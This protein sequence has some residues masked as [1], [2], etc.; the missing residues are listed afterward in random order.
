MANG[1]PERIRF[2]EFELDVRAG[3]LRKGKF[4]VRLQEQ[5]LQLLLVLLENPGK[6]VTREEIRERLWP[7]DTIV[8]FDHGIGTAVKKLRQALNDEAESPRYVETL[9][10]RGF[11]FLYPEVEAIG[12]AGTAKRTAGTIAAAEPPQPLP[13][14]ALPQPGPPAPKPARRRLLPVLLAGIVLVLLSRSLR[15]GGGPA[16]MGRPSTNPA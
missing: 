1:R 5:P 9:P 12:S 10:R 6:V 16:A 14:P 15:A 4:L 7:D 11:R 13:Q 3:E 2:G 8:E